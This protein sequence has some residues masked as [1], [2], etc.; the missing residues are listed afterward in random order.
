MIIINWIVRAILVIA[1]LLLHEWAHV[2][3]IRYFGGKVKEVRPFP[4]GFMAQVSGL[5][6]F[7][8]W[9]RYVA[10]GAG[11]LI[12]AIIATWTLTAS[13]LS[14]VGIGWMEQLAFYNIILCIFNLTPVLPLD[15]GRMLQ[16][17]LANR[18]GALRANRL[19]L[20]MGKI[21]SIIFIILGM[22]QITLFNYN[23]TLLCAGLLISY[24]NKELAPHL[25]TAFYRA[26]RAKY[27]PQ[28]ERLM[29]YRTIIIPSTATLKYALERIPLD[30]ITVFLPDGDK[31][32]AFNER[33]LLTHI[34]TNGLGGTVNDIIIDLEGFTLKLPQG[35][36]SP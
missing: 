31:N 1:S 4:L 6:H 36:T 14:Y 16:Q 33:A 11:V 9:E 21:A 30:Y 2:F 22:V 28:R 19:M 23:I 29:P 8:A 10:Y 7:A 27:T 24:K 25:Q 34:F 17:F 3:A 35:D 12:N 32:R 20:I 5:E 18:I 13:R 15:G 26:I